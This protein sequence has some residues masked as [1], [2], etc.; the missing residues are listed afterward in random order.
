MA[1]ASPYELLELQ[2]GQSVSFHVQAWE[3]GQ[4]TI[5]PA[6]APAGK[7]IPILRVSVSEREKP[8]FPHYWDIT[9][10]RL[11]AQLRPH[12]GRGDLKSLLFTVTAHGF[13]T[14]KSFTLDIRKG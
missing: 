9:S 12:L 4:A 13:Q 2:D 7:V 11:V 5:R 1:I 8:A 6:H 10:A 14:K 3:E